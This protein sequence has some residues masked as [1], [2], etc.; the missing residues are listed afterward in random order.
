M[1]T[2]YTFDPAAAYETIKTQFTKWADETY[3]ENFVLGVSG[4]KDS[5]VVAMLLASI[6]GKDKVHGV[7]LPAG[8]QSDIQDSED[9]IRILGIHRHIINIGEAQNAI[10]SQIENA[11]YDTKTNLPARL[12]MSTIFAVGQTV[13]ARM[14][15]TCNLSED[16]V[17]YATIFGDCAGCFA[18]IQ[19]LTVS[20]VVALGD[21]MVE[22]K[23]EFLWDDD[24]VK[25]A[26][27]PD[28]TR[29]HN[30]IHKTPIDGL[31]PLSDEDKLGFTY[32]S[33]DAFIRKN[34]GTE[35]FKAKIRNIYNKNKFK[36]EIVNMPKVVF[37]DMKNFVIEG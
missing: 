22:N 11:S 28:A 26:E 5:T 23:L 7:M 31:Q 6:F 3:A 18:P 24:S 33:L 4:G 35:E 27:H 19:N 10:L 2:N 8:V 1:T 25:S 12:R 30:L 20:E 13:N 14:I 21:W 32:A 34:E 16:M 36:L 9:V 29:L 15:N 17:G 37:D